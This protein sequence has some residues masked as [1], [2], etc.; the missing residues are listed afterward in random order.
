MTLLQA[1]EVVRSRSAT[2]AFEQTAE[3]GYD[4]CFVV[5]LE[6]VLARSDFDQGDD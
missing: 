5:R 2:R 1:V 3:S 6:S 4:E